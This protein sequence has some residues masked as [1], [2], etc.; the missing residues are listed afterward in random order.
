VPTAKNLLEEA[1]PERLK[2]EQRERWQELHTESAK[3]D[4]EKPSPLKTVAYAV[5]DVG[6]IAPPT[7]IAGQRNK[8]DIAPGVLTILD[9]KPAEIQ[10][11]A[12]ALQSTGRRTALA[13]WLTDPENPLTT[14][15][16]VNRVWQY[17]FGRGLVATS[18]DFGKLGE[19]PSHPDLLARRFVSDGW[20]FKRL[21]RLILTSSVYRQSALH[22]ASDAAARI[23]PERPAVVANGHAA[24]GRRTDPRFHVVHYRRVG[25]EDGRSERV[26]CNSPSD[27]LHQ[28]HSQHP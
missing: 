15:V 8:E 24:A 7:I 23:D 20:S 26:G 21:H 6:T 5:S 27:H 14:R 9:P 22:P 16:I 28:G 1:V 3:F 12:A 13:R 19:P 18:S 4:A 11:P 2:G 10:A 17:Y 25:S